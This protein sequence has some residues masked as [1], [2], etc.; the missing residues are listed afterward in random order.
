MLMGVCDNRLQL[1]DLL[2]MAL[3]FPLA[4]ITLICPNWLHIICSD[5]C[6]NLPDGGEQWVISP[7]RYSEITISS[8]R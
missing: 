8:V 3:P 5:C 6:T 1:L 2:C 7:S 4:L